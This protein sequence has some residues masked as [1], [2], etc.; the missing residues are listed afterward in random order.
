MTRFSLRREAR[1]PGRGHPQA[2]RARRGLA[3]EPLAIEGGKEAG[4]EGHRADDD[5][6]EYGGQKKESMVKCTVVYC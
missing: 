4:H 3:R 2:P 5:G 6:G 1:P